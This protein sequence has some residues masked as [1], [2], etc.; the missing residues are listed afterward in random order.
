MSTY[1]PTKLHDGTALYFDESW[2]A[3]MWWRMLSTESEARLEA[4]SQGRRCYIIACVLM[5]G[6]AICAII[7]LWL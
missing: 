2:P 3:N 4:E 1:E 5:L 7:E 6:N